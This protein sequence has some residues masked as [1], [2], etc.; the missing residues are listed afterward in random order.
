MILAVC[1][2]KDKLSAGGHVGY[3]GDQVKE[4]AILQQSFCNSVLTGVEMTKHHLIRPL[5]RRLGLGSDYCFNSMSSCRDSDL[6][7]VIVLLAYRQ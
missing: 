4:K 1:L 6:P 2:H 7:G 3:W 5:S